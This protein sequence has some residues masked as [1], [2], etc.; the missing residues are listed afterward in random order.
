[1]T[2]LAVIPCK[3]DRIRPVVVECVRRLRE[4]NPEVDVLVVDSDSEDQTYFAEVLALGATVTVLGN[5]NY[6]SGA[7]AWAYRTSEQRDA[8]EFWLLADSLM[9]NAPIKTTGDLTTVR[10]FQNSWGWDEDGTPLQ[11]WG[12]E[13]LARLGLPLPGQFRGVFGPMWFCTR[14]VMVDLEDIGYFDL[15]PTTK[16][17]QSALERVTGIVLEHLGYDVTN[18]LQGQHVDHFGAYDESVVAKLNMARP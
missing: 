17:E 13:Q 1:M 4:H 3:F 16:C 7:Y 14:Q 2:T 9:V 11:V 15:L 8:D 10:W 6:A 18:S 12:G 5:R